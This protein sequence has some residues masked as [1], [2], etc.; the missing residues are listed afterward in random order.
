MIRSPIISTT[1]SWLSPVLITVALF[2]LLRGHHEPGGGFAGGL[3]AGLVVILEGSTRGV[4]RARQILRLP[5]RLWMALGLGAALASGLPGLLS[6]QAFMTA[7]WFS[8]GTLKLGTPLL[9]DL[10]VFALVTGVTASLALPL[11]EDE[12]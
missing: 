12:P 8:I 9:F 5:P 1:L 4:A 10:G 6:G 7:A 11:M 2:L 3:I